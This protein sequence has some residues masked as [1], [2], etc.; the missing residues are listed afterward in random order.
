[1]IA[2]GLIGY[3]LKNTFS[4]DFFSKKFISLG[5]S[6][7]VYRNYPIQNINE[8]TRILSENHDF[9][10]F[11]VTLPHKQHIIPLLDELSEEALACGAVNCIK[12]TPDHSSGYVLKGFNTDVYGFMESIKPL[13]IPHQQN[14]ALVL[15]S[16]GAAKAVCYALKQLDIPYTMVSRQSKDENTISYHTLNK[17]VMESCSIIVNCTPL[18]MFPEM[19]Q[20]P[21]IPYEFISPRHLAYDLIYLPEETLFLSNCRKQGATTK[22]GLEM[23]HLQAEKSWEIWNNPGL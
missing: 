12:A 4:V 9:R 22:N 15:G 10:G 1:M 17:A 5:L 16:G 13:L 20:C 23:L 14:K 3:P 11:N 2:F 6:D 8:F 18:G 21:P 19:N 7:H